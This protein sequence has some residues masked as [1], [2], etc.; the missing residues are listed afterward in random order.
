MSLKKL[1]KDIN[2]GIKHP[3]KS[4][5][6]NI[7]ISENEFKSL[8]NIYFKKLDANQNFELKVEENNFEKVVFLLRWYYNLWI[9]IDDYSIKIFKDFQNV[10]ILKDEVN[11]LN[12]PHIP[13]NF[14][15]NTKMYF[16]SDNYSTC[17]WMKGIPLWKNKDG[18]IVQGC[19]INYTFIE[20]YLE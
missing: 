13:E 5:R 16:T 4:R 15:K 3:I 18:D 20:P 19:Q 9:E 6:H 12:H 17:N 11:K 8:S 1:K 7:V 14:S 2:Y 10:F